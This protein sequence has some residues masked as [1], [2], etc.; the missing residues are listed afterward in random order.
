[1]I[2]YFQSL[3]ERIERKWLAR[4]YNEGVFSQLAQEELEQDPSTGK[5]EVSDVIDWVFSS[6]HAFR[7]PH[8]EHLF[9][10]PP[11]MLFQASR[12]YIEALFWLSGTTAIHEHSFSGVFSLLTGSSV[13]SH[14]RFVPERAIN[15]R[16]ICGQ[17]RRVST[18]VLRPGVVRPIHAGDRLIHQLFHLDLPSVTIVIRT[19]GQ[20]RHLPQY[21]YLPPGLALDTEDGDELRTRRLI[22]LDSMARGQIEGLEKYARTLIENGDLEAIFYL[23]STLVRHKVDQG[24]LQ[25][26]YRTARERHGEVVDFF[27]QV[28]EAERRIRIVTALR[29]KIH[30]PEARF[31]LALLMLMPDRDAI[32]ETIQ[33]QFPDA[34]PLAAIETWLAGMS[35]KETIG[36]EFN[37]VNRI[38]FRGLVEGADTE[39]LLRRLQA[40]FPEEAVHANRDRLL[41]HAKKLVRSNLFS[42]LL[43]RSPLRGPAGLKAVPDGE[44]TGHVV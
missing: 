26:L 44:Q 34:E 18:E 23:F 36:F 40:E 19:Y 6:S 32:L 25:D 43:S 29:S 24:L 41:D 11:V 27:K 3:G 33:L 17:L 16:M 38:I 5:V 12:F 4:S 13:H 15:S 30:D 31:L 22:L 35:G 39:D 20:R 21:M 8:N 28:C 10:E 2:P 37:D 42:P 7:Q 9:G 1:M 14:W